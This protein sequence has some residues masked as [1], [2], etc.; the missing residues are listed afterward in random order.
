MS[1]GPII[2]TSRSLS[3]TTLG[4]TLWTSDQL[5]ADT[6]TWQL[7]TLTRDSH[8][9]SPAGFE[10]AVTAS[11]RPQTHAL[12]RAAELI[13]DPFNIRPYLIGT[14]R[15]G[16]LALLYTFFTEAFRFFKVFQIRAG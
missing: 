11:G 15:G 14:G 16:R 7:T 8:R 4:R 5:V 10:L 9:M 2:E 6:S 3:G 13:L 12:D 1:L